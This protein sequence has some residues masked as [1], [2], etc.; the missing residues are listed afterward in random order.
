MQNE[1][2]SADGVHLVGNFQGFDPDATPMTDANADGIYEVTVAIDTNSTVLYTF[3]NGNTFGAGQEAVPSTCG[4]DNGFGGYNRVAEILESDITLDV[5]C[6]GECTDCEPIVEPLTVDVTF[7]V[8][9][10]N[11]TVSAEGVHLA[12]NFQ[13]FD[14]DA[15]PMTDANADGIYEVTVAID[16]NSTVLYTFINGNTFGAGQEAVPSACGQDNGFGGY[17]RIAEILESDITLDVVCFGECA[18][19]EPIV[20]P[21]TVDVTF[22]VNMQNETVSADGVHLVGN[23]QGFDPDATPMTDANADGIYEVTVA[24]DTNSTVLYTF[25]NGNTFGAGQEAVPSACGQDNG[26]GGYNRV[27]EI[28]ESD[29]T[30]DVVCFGECA[31]CEPIV[32]P[33]TVDVTF[34]VNMQNETV[35]ADG[36]HLVG[37]FQGFDPDATPMTDANADGIYEV[38]VA[39]D[40]NSTVLYTFINGNTFGAGQ[41][42]VPS[43]CGQDNGF[44]GY[45][46][47][48]EILESD[49][50][51]DVVCFGECTDCEPIV[52]PLTVDVT[53]QVNMQNETVSADGVHLVGNFQGFDPDATPMTDANADGIYEV[54]VAI[55]TNS[56]VLYTFINGNTFGAGQ[57]AVPS[58]CGQD[59]GFGGYNRVAEILESD[60]TLDVVC[61]GECADCEPI[62][63]TPVNVTFQV[64]MSEQIVSADGVTIVGTFIDGVNAQYAMTDDNADEIYEVTLE[65]DANQTILY[66]FV[67]GLTALEEESVPA[68]CSTTGEIG[69]IR[70]FIQTTTSD[71]IL[72]AVCFSSCNLCG[73]QSTN[74]ITFQVN[75]VNETVSADGVHI[76]GNFQNWDPAATELTDGNGDGIYEV[77]LEL[78]EWANLNYKFINGNTWGQAESVP[79]SCGLPDGAG[80]YNRILETGSN[81]IVV[82]PVC[83]GECANCAGVGQLVDVTFL[84][85]MANVTVSPD[86][87]HLAGNIQGWNPSSTEMT[88]TDAD[89]IYEVTL[90]V[91][92]GT[93]AEFRFVNGNDWPFSESVPALCGV[94]NGFGQNNRTYL[95][96]DVDGTYGP[97]CFGA[98]VDCDDIVEPTLVNMHL[99][100]NMLNE[101]IS[102]DGVHVAGSFQGWNPATTEMTDDDMDGIYEVDVQVPVNTAVQFKFI[103]GNAWSGQESVPAACGVDDGFGGLNRALE[104]L[105]ADLSF[106]P[107]CFGECEDCAPFTPVIVIF[108]VDM[109]NELVS[110]DGVYIA[111]TF[112]GWDPTATQMSEYEPGYYQAVV[113]LNQNEYVEYKFINGMEWTGSEVVPVECG[114][115]DGNGGLNRSYQAGTDTETLPLVCFSQ[116]AACVIV[117][118]VDITFTVDM[119]LQT[120]DPAGVYLAGSFNGFSPTATQ[121]SEVGSDVYSVTVTVPQNTQVTFKYLNG[122]SFTGVESVPFECGVDDGF[123]GYNRVVNADNVDINLPEVCFGSCVDCP[124]SVAETIGGSF[125]VYPNPADEQVTIDFGNSAGEELIVTDATGKIIIRE[126]LLT[127][128]T[129]RL[130]TSLW[131]AGIYQ[132]VV[133][134]VGTRTLVID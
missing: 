13:G 78:D 94:P 10:Q 91:E 22:Q 71:L 107:V 89:G 69:E 70:R 117:P 65:V 66:A 21:L 128:G 14:P 2:V 105:D 82:S 110:G 85:N 111:G 113:V 77:T 124:V 120:V 55:D 30:L 127:T 28:L 103:N 75:M 67:N 97:V 112:N 23:F 53:F 26:F 11:E 84:V 80:G 8:N 126:K 60:I 132:I 16:T 93:V 57:E 116:C 118:E 73:A 134:S 46:R 38:T 58:A 3:I 7:Q 1:T 19:C 119:S 33:L 34:Q 47:V 12:G 35:S 123:G 79:S 9:M 114:V 130:N 99:E 41:E 98:C 31:D 54:T 49:I 52:E 64:N 48:A 121:M 27:A 24:I 61:F 90:E 50:T 4:Q 62:V 87:V 95:V 51:L 36:V 104:V 129:F 115:D 133:P 92:S 17:N 32:E 29:I 68:Q 72:P 106:G 108:R 88:D 42:A 40:T 44:G 83:F 76:A 122:P 125:R 131:S 74:Q 6:F 5:V 101:D 39:I 86:G 37:N 102:A 63:E 45:N 43:T 81:D 20:E 56:T 25:I 59:N 18:D 15:T 96:G 109:S 100:V